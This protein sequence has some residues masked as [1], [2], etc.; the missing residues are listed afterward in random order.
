MDEL[1]RANEKAMLGKDLKL[2]EEAKKNQEEYGKI[3]DKQ[4]KDLENDRKKEEYKKKI[5]LEHNNKLKYF[6]NLIR[7]QIKMKEETEK[8][9]ERI[10]DEEGRKRKQKSLVEK[11]KLEK[12][13]ENK[14][15]ELK[16]MNLD[17]KYLF[18]L[19]KYKVK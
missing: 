1:I 11:L 17:D 16:K 6:L 2:A 9:K 19:Q 14:I 3:I 8:Q 7:K 18:D 13:R 5:L 15:N 4:L 12:V 10:E